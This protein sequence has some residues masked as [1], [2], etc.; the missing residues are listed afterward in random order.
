MKRFALLLTG[1]LLLATAP[2]AN[3][4]SDLGLKNLGLAVGFVSPENLDMTFSIGGF[5][6]WGTIAPDIGLE[7]RLDFWSWSETNFGIETTI[8]DI[9]LGA[10]GKYYFKTANPKVRPFA[11]T[12]IGIH[13]VTAEV[14]V[15]PSTGFPESR[16]SETRTKMGLDLGGGLATPLNPRTDFLAEA[17]YGIVS[18]VSQ[19]SLRA[20]LTY[21]IGK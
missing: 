11:G 1:A 21:K 4:Q 16:A 14:Y 5:A 3:A 8:R 7:S 20:G 17:W 12:G 13:F 10:R 9:T 15:D 19:F 2:V 18:D 6:D